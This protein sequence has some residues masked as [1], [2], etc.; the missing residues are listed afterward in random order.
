MRLILRGEP[1]DVQDNHSTN[2]NITVSKCFQ[3]GLYSHKL[4]ASQLERGMVT[5][6]KNW[7]LAPELVAYTL[8]LSFSHVRLWLGHNSSS[9]IIVDMEYDCGELGV[10]PP[11]SVVRHTL[12]S[13]KHGV[14]LVTTPVQTSHPRKQACVRKQL[15]DWLSHWNCQYRT[16]WEKH[17]SAYLM[18]S[19]T[20]ILKDNEGEGHHL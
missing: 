6:E 13:A 12:W 9:P 8:M 18:H 2:W 4:L 1:P 11:L 15:L 16:T 10:G 19:T 17:C 5:E 7:D 20:S 14:N 3:S